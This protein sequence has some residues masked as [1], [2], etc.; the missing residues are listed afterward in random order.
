M[1]YIKWHIKWP[2]A[3]PSFLGGKTRRSPSR[4]DVE[5]ICL[6]K[7]WFVSKKARSELEEG[8]EIF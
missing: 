4:L 6:I 3:K 8:E 5:L 1:D 2:G 7:Q